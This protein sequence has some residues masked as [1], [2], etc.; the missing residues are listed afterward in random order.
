L[1]VSH[2]SSTISHQRNVNI[3]G[4]LSKESHSN[5]SVLKSSISL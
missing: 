1:P 2:S 3:I 5:L 4:E